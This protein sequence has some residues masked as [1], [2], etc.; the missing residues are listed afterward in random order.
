MVE[1]SQNLK[2][3]STG[4]HGLKE[5]KN[6][7]K[8][9]HDQLKVVQHDPSTKFAAPTGPGGPSS[10]GPSA[11]AP[12]TEEKFKYSCGQCDK[13]FQR[14]NE[15]QAHITFKHGEGYQCSFCQHEPFASQAAL[16]VHKSTKHGKQTAKIYNCDS[17]DYTSNRKDAVLAH[18]IKAHNLVLSE[19]EKV[20]CPNADKGCTKLSIPKNNVG[21][22]LGSFARKQ[23]KS[24]VN[25]K[26]V[27]EN[28]RM[29]CKCSP[30][31]RY[32]LKKA[33]SGSARYVTS[34]VLVF[35]HSS[36]I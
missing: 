9:T 21:G 12:S 32:T 30:I 4:L 31:T 20:K 2:E 24:N 33:R 1:M 36:S 17:C 8:L 15:L 16:N 10:S 35:S 3:V 27:T 26:D 7:I 13:R 11:A 34:N 28:S 5:L 14:S 6:F 19:E 23:Q 25:M 29:K 18:K 22:I